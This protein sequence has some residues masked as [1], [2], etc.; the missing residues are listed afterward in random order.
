MR[1]TLSLLLAAF[2]LLAAAVMPAASTK[3]NALRAAQHLTYQKEP[4]ETEGEPD[5][6]TFSSCLPLL[7][8]DTEG[9]TI[10]GA[11]QETEEKTLCRFFLFDGGGRNT[12]QDTPAVESAALVNI[13]GHSSRYYPKKQ[14]AVKLVG[15]DGSGNEQS[16]CGMAAG[17]SYAVNGSYIDRTQIR[18]YMLYQISDAV[19]GNAPDARL[20]EMF[21]RDED[22]ETEYL[23][24]YTIIERIQTDREHLNLTEFDSARTE[25]AALLQINN[26]CDH[27]KIERLMSTEAGVYDCDLLYPDYL[28]MSPEQ[29]QWTESVFAAYEK[30]L[31]DIDKN[32]DSTDWMDRIDVDSFVDYFLINEFFQNYDAGTLS[33]FLYFDLDGVVHI[34]P[35]WDFDGAMNNTIGQWVAYDTIEMPKN[36]IYYYLCGSEIFTRLCELRYRELRKSYLS[37]EYLLSYIDACRDYLGGSLAR[38]YERWYCSGEETRYDRR[39]GTVEEEYDKLREYVVERGRW[40]DENIEKLSMLN[41]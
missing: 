17:D 37:E 18:N 15:D 12:L 31:M 33:T 6:E 28:Q 26:T 24:L 2:L 23:G 20:C 30:S 36:M 3:G 39:R 40:M 41:G 19:M 38:N 35:V 25:N 7:L 9:Q 34:G 21:L 14:Y 1:R 22:G 4:E 16:L 29:L 32:P 27:Y 5:A 8:I 10:P 11:E 13:R